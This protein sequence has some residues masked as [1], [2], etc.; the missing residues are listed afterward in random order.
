MKKNIIFVFF[1]T[2]IM[3]SL[4]LL[5]DNKALAIDAQLNFYITGVINTQ[6]IYGASWNM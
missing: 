6:C 5:S 3:F 4:L 1:I 2:I